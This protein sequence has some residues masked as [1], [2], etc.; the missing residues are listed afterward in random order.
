MFDVKALAQAAFQPLVEHPLTLAAT[1]LPDH[2]HWLL[3]DCRSL[4]STVGRYKSLV[5]ARARAQGY[6]H[7]IWQRSFWDHIVRDTEKLDRIVRYVLENPIR[8]GLCERFEDYPYTVVFPDRI[9][10]LR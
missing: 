8:A 6:P 9:D 10:D 1:I 4:S 2:A 5:T 3:L 7:R